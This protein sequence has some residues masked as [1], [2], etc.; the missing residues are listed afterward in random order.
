VQ[1][2]FGRRPSFSAGALALL[3]PMGLL[4]A[5]KRIR[6]GLIYVLW[7]IAGPLAVFSFGATKHPWYLTP[8][9][10][11]LAIGM[12]LAINAGVRKAGEARFLSER[13]HRRIRNYGQIGGALAVVLIVFARLAYTEVWHYRHPSPVPFEARYN[14]LFDNLHRQ[15]VRS[16]TVVDGGV[17]NSERFVNY[18]PQLRFYALLWRKKGLTTLDILPDMRAQPGREGE[19]AAT[20]DQRYIEALSQ[21][22]ERLEST[23]GCLAIRLRGR[24]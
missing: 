3:A 23:P 14:A 13:L 7:C 19:V 16:M 18:T 20:C 4:W 24:G 10:P 15:G 8:A 2:L 11:L 22:G 5:T 17:D 21:L 1:I 12:A 6:L 9:Y